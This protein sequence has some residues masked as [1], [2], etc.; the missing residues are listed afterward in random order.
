MYEQRRLHTQSPAFTSNYHTGGFVTR[1]P[2]WGSYT[3]SDDRVIFADSHEALDNEIN[4]GK[5]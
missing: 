5:E 4:N 3:T 1:A 2:L